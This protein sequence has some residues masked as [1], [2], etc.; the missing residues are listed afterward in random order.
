MA[1]LILDA[2][3]RDGMSAQLKAIQKHLS[4]IGASPGMKEANG[5]L[6]KLGQEA[7]N[8][9]SA[10]SGAASMLTGLGV[11]GLVAAGSLAAMTA[12]MKALAERQLSMKELGREIGMTT[13]QVNAFSHAG[14]HFGVSG[15]AMAHMVEHMAGQMPQFRAGI[16]GMIADL[17]N[18]PK[19][20][21]RLRTESTEDQLTEIFS[22]FGKD[23]KFQANPQLQKQ[24]LGSIFGDA[25]S[26]E[27]LMA[28]QFA[29]FKAQWDKSIKELNPIS[30]DL[31][32]ADQKYRDA[33]EHFNR[34]LENFENDY[35]PKFLG[36][37][38]GILTVG[39]QI[40]SPNKEEGEA[41]QRR[42]DDRLAK[43]K[44]QSS[45]TSA[46]AGK[47]Q[48]NEGAADERKN[49]PDMSDPRIQDALR[50]KSSYS[51]SGGLLHNASFGDSGRGAMP[52]MYG[53]EEAIAGGTKT[54]FLAAFREITAAQDLEK[55]RGSGFSKASYGGDGFPGLGGGG[56][57]Q[58]GSGGRGAGG[59]NFNLKGF[60]GKL[61]RGK[62]WTPDRQGHAVDR[63]MKEGGL[64]QAGAEGL[65]SRWAN[66]EAG[67]G[68]TALNPSSGAAGIAQWLG[69]RRQGFTGDYDSQLSHALEELKGPES[70]AGKALRG[71]KD[72]RE[73]A[74]GASMFERAEGY[75]PRTGIDNFT[76]KSLAGASRVHA[77]IAGVAGKHF[78]D[79]AT[80]L[81]DGLD[82]DWLAHRGGKAP[83]LAPP[84]N[85]TPPPNIY[86]RKATDLD[87]AAGANTQRSQNSKHELEIRIHDRGSNVQGTSLR[88]SGLMQVNLRR[89][90]GMEDNYG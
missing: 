41:A 1:D 12:Q 3:V 83:P 89:Y 62:W 10:G 24:V 37:L 4:A 80:K 45:A 18:W 78:S 51:G 9:V 28:E 20:I 86:D 88:S 25:D 7:K 27:K 81:K 33:Q 77:E 38:T 44:A 40:F 60:G 47:E 66:V 58:G 53:F 69:A 57:G 56:A 79:A 26:A 46:T 85:W 48:R 67:A 54:G 72:A 22:F 82:P 59:G 17:S 74:I 64:S 52:A 5:W 73:G 65:V 55:T 84:T 32:I 35:G 76:A 16:G 2:E 14:A 39:S 63:L 31:L 50:H 11:G 68:P 23:P 29:G 36:L 6:T 71:A 75:N 8:F 87:A 70:R 43:L 19:L 15:E 42:M 49:A 13:D 90:P 30:P 61:N 34:S 21:E